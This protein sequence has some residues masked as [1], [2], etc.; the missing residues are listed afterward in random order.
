[1]IGNRNEMEKWLTVSLVRVLLRDDD[2]PGSASSFPVSSP[3]FSREV[4]GPATGFR[5]LAPTRRATV[6]G[7][8]PDACKESF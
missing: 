6:V 7:V 2:P 3:P 5:S 4:L 8:I 1:M